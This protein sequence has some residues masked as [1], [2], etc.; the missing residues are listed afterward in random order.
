MQTSKT[1]LN[2][3]LA[4]VPATAQLGPPVPPP[5]EPVPPVTRRSSHT[6]LRG[7]LS[8]SHGQWQLRCRGP[9][10]RSHSP[11][12][13]PARSPRSPPHAVVSLENRATCLK[14]RN[15]VKSMIILLLRFIVNRQ[16]PSKKHASKKELVIW[17]STK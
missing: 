7:P 13:S 5:H 16:K 1:F 4:P 11:A 6:G 10:A 3:F 17:I 2:S 14:M 12:S 15:S 8:G 9:C